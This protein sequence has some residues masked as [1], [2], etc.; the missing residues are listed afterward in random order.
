M[1]S[2]AAHIRRG[3]HS[4]FEYLMLD[5]EVPL[6][7]V[8]PDRLRRNG[9]YSQRELQTAAADLV[10]TDDVKLRRSLNQRWS[11]FKRLDVAFVSICVL[12]EDAVAAA[13]RRL[14]VAE[15]I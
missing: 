12:E 15:H 4:V 3:E 1:G 5:V 14:T 11:A 8:W 9:D 10:V 6:L 13:Q 2:L 7:H